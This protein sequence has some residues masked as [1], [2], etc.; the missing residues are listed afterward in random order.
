MGWLDPGDGSFQSGGFPLADKMGKKGL[1]YW[2]KIEDNA[3]G[4]NMEGKSLMEKE[5]NLEMAR[6]R[7][8]RKMTE[9]GD[10]R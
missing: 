8:L 10:G 3:F 2:K 7:A 5:K 9:M 1:K 6:E 4:G